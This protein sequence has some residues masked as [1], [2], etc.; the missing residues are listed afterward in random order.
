MSEDILTEPPEKEGNDQKAAVG[1]EVTDLLS[2]PDELEDAPE[3]D[4][5]P[6]VDDEPD[7]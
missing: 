1:T 6:D 2:A 7:E 5:K 4:D 3:L